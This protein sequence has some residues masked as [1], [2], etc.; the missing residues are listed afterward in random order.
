M[1]IR[2]LCPNGHQLTAPES[3]AGKAGK[4]PKCGLAFAVPTLEEIG[5]AETEGTAEPPA[6]E[7]QSEPEISGSQASGSIDLNLQTNSGS[8]KSDKGSNVFVFLCP[9]GHKLNG[10]PTLKGKAGQCPHCG[11]RFRI[12][13]DDDLEPEEVSEPVPESEPEPEIPADEPLDA[14]LA[15]EAP[16]E[17]VDPQEPEEPPAEEVY[18]DPPAETGHALGYVFARLWD[19]RYEGTE[20]EL[21][22]K[23]GD[24][25]SPEY[26]C[27]NL[28]CREY[29][30][31]ANKNGDGEFAFT[32]IHW[33]D[34]RK[35][36]VKKIPL[37]PRPMFR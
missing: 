21:Y 34:V 22:L 24:L 31:F 1:V 13:S 33:D 16:E 35:V 10:P 29:G 6:E 17:I 9:N 25:L 27:D 23:D 2:F 30:V 11:A 18:V 12:P 7:P 15:E 4:C 5:A 14:E 19:Q 32:L 26:Y 28:S 36:L 3:L 37:L 8:A 20:V